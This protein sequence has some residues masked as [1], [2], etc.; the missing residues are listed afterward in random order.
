MVHRWAYEQARGAIPPGLQL[1]HLC[2]NRACYQVDHLEAVTGPENDRRAKWR[3][4]CRNG[5]QYTPENTVWQK[6]GTRRCRA[7][8]A[9]SRARSEH[10]R[11]ERRGTD[12]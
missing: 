4:A 10:R 11:R 8:Q 3:P 2:R 7:C 5:H 6:D 12:Q 1:D 9:A